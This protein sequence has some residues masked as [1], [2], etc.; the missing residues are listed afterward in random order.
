[1]LFKDFGLYIDDYYRI[2]KILISIREGVVEILTTIFSS[3]VNVRPLHGAFIYALSYAGFSF[4]G[5]GGIYII[6]FVILSINAILCF[7]LINTLAKNELTSL[8]G[9]LAFVLYPASTTKIWITAALGI[10]PAITLVLLA[11]VFYLKEMQWLSYLF[12]VI[13]LFCYETVYWVFFA[14][15]LFFYPWNRSIQNK[16]LKHGIIMACIFAAF[17]IFK[18]VGSDP[19]LQDSSVSNLL[20]KSI[21]HLVEGPFYNLR[22]QLFFLVKTATIINTSDIIF[23][24]IVSMAITL[25]IS[26]VGS[27]KENDN[28]DLH[29]IRNGTLVASGNPLFKGNMGNYKLTLIGMVMLILAYPLTLNGSVQTVYGMESRFHLSASIGTAFIY[30]GVCARILS[31]FDNLKKGTIGRFLLSIMASLLLLN[32]IQIQKD[33]RDAYCVQRRFWQDFLNSYHN[34]REDT[35]IFFETQAVKRFRSIPTFDWSSAYILE[36]IYTFPENWERKPRVYVVNK[37]GLSKILNTM[38]EIT[39][40]DLDKMQF[41]NVVISSDFGRIID[42]KNSFIV[43]YDSVPPNRLISRTTNDFGNRTDKINSG[44]LNHYSKGVLYKLLLKD[45]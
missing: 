8:I 23:L 11:F 15:P 35:L 27:R 4:G 45:I 43:Y 17:F 34:F 12:V 42:K 38:D 39:L 7:V 44:D 6:G 31:F 33:Y 9:S 21:E 28:R 1:M 26:I 5:L 40:S 18:I 36:N 3:P 13:S 24:I 19:R 30:A 2:T 20:L 32:G 14:A 41:I 37:P 10:Q 16:V 22:G 25:V 29:L